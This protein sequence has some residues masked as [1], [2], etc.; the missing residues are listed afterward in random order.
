[1]GHSATLEIPPA[2]IAQVLQEKLSD[3][4]L[5]EFQILDILIILPK[6]RLSFFPV[7]GQEKL[8]VFQPE[9]KV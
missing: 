4:I 1:M 2:P 5:T 8:R 9:L 3:E 6:I 7:T